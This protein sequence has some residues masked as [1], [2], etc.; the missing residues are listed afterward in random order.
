M[1]ITKFTFDG[2]PEEFAAVRPMF[3]DEQSAADNVPAAQ[4]PLSVP[5]VSA[6]ATPSKE[7][8]EQAVEAFFKRK[9][10]LK[11][12][13]VAIIKHVMK[14]GAA[15]ITSSELAKHVGSV[16][17]VKQPMRSFG[18]RV[19][20]T[21]HWPAGVSM[22]NQKWEGKENRYRIHPAFVTAVNSGRV[23]L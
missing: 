17:L 23:T 6:A 5:N 10:P 11:P 21:P 9:P 22:F 4:A 3:E 16:P 20:H 1:R 13:Q 15:G 12:E 19:A 8:S 2:T 7:P 14:A 18:K